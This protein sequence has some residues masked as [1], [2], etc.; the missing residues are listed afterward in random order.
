MNIKYI[1][2]VGVMEEFNDE[3]QEFELIYNDSHNYHIYKINYK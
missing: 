2:T 3:N 1:F